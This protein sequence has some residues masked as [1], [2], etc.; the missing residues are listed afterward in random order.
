[1]LLGDETGGK[2][3]SV[4]AR[5]LHQRS[6]LGL[7]QGRAAAEWG[8]TPWG[9]WRSERIFGEDS[10]EM[11]KSRFRCGQLD[12]YCGPLTKQEKARWGSRVTKKKW[13]SGADPC[14]VS[15][16]QAWGRW[17]HGAGLP[18]RV[19]LGDLQVKSRSRMGKRA[20]EGA[21]S[22]AWKERVRGPSLPIL[23]TRGE[24][25]QERRDI[26]ASERSKSLEVHSLRL[27]PFQTDIL[28]S[29]DRD[30]DGESV[31]TKC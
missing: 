30:N 20:L 28:I 4:A 11:E 19:G 17:T 25:T 22:T 26:R 29:Y 9:T 7:S 6:D 18:I 16:G 14:G 2:E 23:G 3:A 12:G 15:K 31:K 13:C 5:I 21:L 27:P 1:M 8:C 24:G 10:V